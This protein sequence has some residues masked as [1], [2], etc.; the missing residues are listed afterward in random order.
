MMP[1]V[2]AATAAGYGDRPA[3]RRLLLLDWRPLRK[4]SLRGF[5][6]VQLPSGLQIID[7]PVL[8]SHGRTWAGLPGKPQL[9][10][11]GRQR[12][13]ATGKALYVAVLKWKDPELR[14]R[15]SDAIVALIRASHPGDI[16]QN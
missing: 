12:A 14:D 13:D 10:S 2:D 6:S 4:A 15:F 3:P 5:A 9:D 7:C 8:F 11:T 1:D 16:E